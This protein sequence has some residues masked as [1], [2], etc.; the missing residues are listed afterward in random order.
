[1][2]TEVKERELKCLGIVFTVD[3]C[4]DK[5]RPLLGCKDD[6]ASRNPETSH[7]ELWIIAIS[8][9]PFPPRTIHYR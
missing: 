9:C 3:E 4:Q 8:I 2:M 5:S 7:F 6:Q 1:M